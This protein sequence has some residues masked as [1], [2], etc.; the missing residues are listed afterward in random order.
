V[1]LHTP[2]KI[3]ITPFALKVISAVKKIPRGKVATYG[4]VARLAGKPHASRAV[5][6]ILNSCARSHQLP[7]QRV[8]NSRG[9]ISF[10]RESEE[11]AAQRRLLLKEGI[12]VSVTGALSLA[13]YQWRKE[14]KRAKA[15]S[16]RGPSM[17]SD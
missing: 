8:L 16:R 6:W 14:P 9:T 5:G 7:W 17:F 2:L 1:G 11:F 15:T 4:Q 3:K 12:E 13:I 10:H